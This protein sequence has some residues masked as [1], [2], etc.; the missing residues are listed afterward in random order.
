MRRSI[1]ALAT[2][3][4]IGCGRLGFA[5]VAGDPDPELGPDGGM[6]DSGT[7]A[8][9]GDSST[10]PPGATSL[11]VPGGMYLRDNN[12]LFDAETSAFVLDR[13]EVSVARFRV[14]VDG[15]FGTQASPPPPLSG[16]HPAIEA[17]GWKNSWNTALVPRTVDL[18]DRLTTI[19]NPTFTSAPGA[20]EQL[21]IVGVTWYEA[22]AFCI[23][24]GG[25]LPTVAEHE[26]AAFGGDQ[27]RG[28]PWGS[29][30]VQANVV[31]GGGLAPVGSRSPHGDARWGH[32]DLVGNADEWALDFDGLMPR[33]CSD[34]ANLTPNPTTPTRVLLG[35]NFADPSSEF[36]QSALS[37]GAAPAQRHGR[38]GFRCARNADPAP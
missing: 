5:P 24:D 13:V 17:S 18:I 35:G 1:Q 34:C 3:V 37:H 38:H 27:Q 9:D 16:E 4:L 22:F 25:R 32:A 36:H 21:P 19:P 31:M 15:G 7:T 11:P 33:P 23:W 30:F 29:T 12:L 8:L 14:F 2:T 20:N 28:Y 6:N 26:L 10:N